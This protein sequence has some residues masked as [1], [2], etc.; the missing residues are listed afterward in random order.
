MHA[1]A[2]FGDFDLSS[3]WADSV[4]PEAAQEIVARRRIVESERDTRLRLA[5]ERRAAQPV[6]PAAPQGRQDEFLAALDGVSGNAPQ[7]LLAQAMPAADPSVSVAPPASSPRTRLPVADGSP[8]AARPRVALEDLPEEVRDDVEESRQALVQQALAAAPAPFIPVEDFVLDDT[9]L[10]E[11]RG[12]KQKALDNIEAIKTAKL[13][14]MAGRQATRDEKT[15]MARYVGWGGLQ[16]AFYDLEGKTKE[17]WEGIARQLQDVLTSEEYAKARS[18]ILDAHYTAAEVVRTIWAGVSRLG[19]KGGSVIEPAGGSGNFLGLQPADTA[20][21][22]QRVLV[23]IDPITSSIARLLYSRA[24]VANAPFETFSTGGAKFDLFIGNPPFGDLRLIDRRGAADQSVSALSTRLSTST[25]GYF[26]ARAAEGLRAGGVAAMVVSRY[27]LDG[28]T[29]DAV[30]FRCALGREVELIDAVRLP[31]TAFRRNAG[32]EVV[33]DIVFLRKRAEPISEDAA[34]DLPWVGTVDMHNPDSAS[35]DAF[36]TIRIN[37]WYQ[38]HP[39]KILGQLSAGRGMYRDGELMVRATPDWMERLHAAMR[40]L[41]E[42]SMPAEGVQALLIP[43][44]AQS[45]SVEPPPGLLP[46]QMFLW[47]NPGGADAVRRKSALAAFGV[48][49]SEPVE[50]ESEVARRRTVA[51][52]RL[53]ETLLELMRAQ[54]DPLGTESMVEDLREQLRARYDVFQNEYG[55]LKRAVNKRLVRADPAWTLLSSLEVNYDDG[56]SA[57]VAKKTEST[58]RAPRADRAD[59]FTKRTQWPA[60]RAQKAD[61]ARDALVVSLGES[62]TV[63]PTRMME[64]TGRDWWDLRD[65]LGELV[66]FDPI[67]QRWVERAELVSGDVLTKCELARQAQSMESSDTARRSGA[68]RSPR[69]AAE[70]DRSVAALATAAPTRKRAS[71]IVVLPGASWVP[72]EIVRAF[73]KDICGDTARVEYASQSGKWAIEGA[74][75]NSDARY[76]TNRKTAVDILS[77][78]FNGKVPIVHDHFDGNAVVNQEQTALAKQKVEAVIERWLEFV[79]ETP[80]RAQAIEDAWNATFNRTVQRVYDGSHLTLEGSSAAITLRPHQKNAI[81]RA[82]QSDQVLFDH[83]VGAGKTFAVVGSVMESRR[84]GRTKKSMVV[85]PNHLVGQWRDAFA[86]LYP[87]AR[88]LAAEADDMSAG[89]RQQFLARA[90][91]GDWD[92]I[93]MPHSSFGLIPAD[94]DHEMRYIGEQIAL[95][96]QDLL[97]NKERVTRKELEKAIKRAEQ[98]ILGLAK[99]RKDEGIHFGMLGV[100]FLAVDEAHAFKNVSYTTQLQVSGLGNPEGSAR[101]NDMMIKT[102]FIRASGGKALFATGT[103][104]SNSLAEMYTL[105][106]YLDPDTL[107]AQR[108]HSFDAWQRCYAQITSDFA[109]TLTGKFKEKTVLSRFVNLDGLLASYRSFAD[110]ITRADMNR[111]LEQAGQPR[112]DI[113]DVRGGKPAI[114]VSPM[115]DAQRRMMGDQVDMNDSGHPIYEMGSI[116]WRLDNLPKGAPKKGDDNVLVIISDIRKVGLDARAFRPG[117]ADNGGGKLQACAD[118]VLDSWSR[119]GD[120]RGTQL[121]FLDFC[122]PQA[123]DS[124]EVRR[125]RDLIAQSESDDANAAEAAEDEL[126]KF[127]Q[128]EVEAALRTGGFDAYAALRGEL[129]KRG[130]PGQ[131]IAFIHDYDTA[132]KRDRLFAAVNAGEI[133][134]LVGST[135]KMGAGMNVQRLIT[136]VHH[137]DAPYRPSDLEQRNGRGLRQGNALLAKYGH[138]AFKVGIHYYVTED[139]GDAGL[140][141]IVDTKLTFI[142]QVRTG[143]SGGEIENPESSAIDPGRVKAMASGNEIL[144][145]EVRLKDEA[146]KK[147]RLIRAARQDHAAWEYRVESIRQSIAYLQRSLPQAR[148][149]QELGHTAV[150]AVRARTEALQREIDDAQATG[151]K[152]PA[153]SLMDTVSKIPVHALATKATAARTDVSLAEVGGLIALEAVRGAGRGRDEREI[154]VFDGIALHIASRYDY[155]V[156]PAIVRAQVGVGHGDVITWSG[157]TSIA[158]TDNAAQLGRM[159]WGLVS[160]DLLDIHSRAERDLCARER[161]L[162]STIANQPQASNAAAIADLSDARERHA[163]AVFALRLGYRKWDAFHADAPKRAAAA[164][165][166]VAETEQDATAAPV[167]A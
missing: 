158:S 31:D 29:V 134:V 54:V 81:W 94:P 121:V 154:G 14:L 70:I 78:A 26:F 27:L 152:H 23:E 150:E 87:A 164:A 40:E 148:S 57:A 75:Y 73:A 22:S 155:S 25:H 6:G 80:E 11:E 135:S 122:T 104:I 139:S 63:D 10:A 82:I 61:S 77:C 107:T 100:D 72:M 140:W 95:L 145:D 114:H 79:T 9:I 56:V 124:A 160:E 102:S 38:Q 119:Y 127:S 123:G 165:Q 151:R 1:Q 15:T 55:Y 74:R 156:Y 130:I 45:D 37:G 113:P 112:I 69:M 42:G 92:A 89:N 65:E 125:M 106:R 52:L 46:G 108:L 48:E 71:E 59:I 141:Q 24:F 93:I 162:A 131:Q 142:E 13:V 62:G 128:A 126:A 47:R 64:L 41:P 3:G 143:V 146:Q 111:L 161:D 132:V 20:A 137:L 39:E 44:S 167:S 166:N 51:M 2:L 97:A 19:F 144:M 32:T 118:N 157:S 96:K 116:L 5:Q 17:D 99:T 30:D 35:V 90:A 7:D 8:A 138:D 66:L 83:V 4:S 21:K 136:D 50:F 49:S 53:H 147:E 33:T 105:Q 103:P 133:R 60:R 58:A 120:D 68:G 98:R 43:A 91:F 86:A 84:M 76:S 88:I 85:V 109:F 117:A 149:L 67:H 36:P 101:A 159:V 18:T 34:R 115:S 28:S 163:E 16:Y 110:V 12:P 153:K 129:L